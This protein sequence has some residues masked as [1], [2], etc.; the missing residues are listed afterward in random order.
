M[1]KLQ[2]LVQ[3]MTYLNNPLERM[4]TRTRLQ[5]TGSEST[6]RALQECALSIEGQLRMRSAFDQ[7]VVRDVRWPPTSS[8]GASRLLLIP[9]RSRLAAAPT[10]IPQ[11][12]AVPA[13]IQNL[14]WLPEEGDDAGEVLAHL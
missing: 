9:P 4:A 14:E 12:T 5:G 11:R 10:R 1:C 2:P 13:R 7:I 3:S 8:Q 6:L